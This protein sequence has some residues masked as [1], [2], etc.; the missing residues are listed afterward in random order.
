MPGENIYDP[1]FVTRLFNEMSR[2]Y[3]AVNV[4]SS[5]GFCIWWRRKCLRQAQLKPGMQVLDLMSGM[6]ELWPGITR[7]IQPAGGIRGIDLSPEMCRRAAHNADKSRAAGVGVEI[8]Q[9]DALNSD[10]ADA[11]ADALVCSFGLKTLNAQQQELLARE[12]CRV[13]KPGAPFSFIE[14]SV[15]PNSLLRLPY[16]F[17][18]THMIPLIGRIFLGN[19]SN[20]RC[21][22]TYTTAFGNTAA[23]AR[24]L[25]EQDLIVEEYSDF[26]GCAT[27]IKGSR[28]AAR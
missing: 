5:F 3:G 13:L 16:M 28:P 6:G 2:T 26:F 17:Y 20:Y 8:I 14:I 23:F 9:T 1:K 25:R 7:R 19:P 22:S 12:V 4:V 21:L 10:L 11:S 24:V 27:G 15:P 18:V